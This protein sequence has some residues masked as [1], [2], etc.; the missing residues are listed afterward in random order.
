M[1]IGNTKLT[2]EQMMMAIIADNLQFLSWT[3]TKDAKHGKYKQKSILKMLQ[4]EYDKT[5]DDL[6]SFKTVEEYEEYM[7]Q[8]IR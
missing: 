1:K 4:G 7:K 8:F 3:K 6:I 2:I 5:K